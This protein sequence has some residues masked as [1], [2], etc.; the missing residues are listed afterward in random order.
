MRLVFVA[1][2]ALIIAQ[3]A[4]AGACPVNSG[5]DIAVYGQTGTGGVGD[6]SRSWMVHFFD[7][8]KAQDASLDYAMLDAAD[9]KSDCVLAN[10]PGLKLYVEPGGD[11]YKQQKALG[12]A[13][14]SNIL[15]FIDGGK[16]YLGVCAGFYYAANDYY[17]QGSYYDWPY[18]LDRFPTVEGSITSIADYEGDP[19]YAMTGLGNGH[20]VLYYGGPTRGWSQTPSTYPGVKMA[21]FSA[22]PG[23]LPAVIANGN[24]LLTSVHLEAYENDGF[25]GLTTAQRVENYKWLANM[26]NGVA[27][28]S[29]YVPPYTQC[30]DGIDNDDDGNT[31]YPADPGCASIE[32][33]SETN[34]QCSDGLDNDNDSFVDYPADAGCS[35]AS[36]NDETDVS[37]PVQLFFD[38]FESGSLS[39]WTLSK[40]SGANFWTAATTN[41]YQGSYHAQAR[42][43]Y[44]TEPATSMEMAVSTAG[45]GAV[46]VS[47][48]RR[49]VGLDPA[50][51]FKAK[52]FDGTSW[53]VMEETGASSANDAA[54]VQKQFVLPAPAGDNPAFGIKFECTAGATT[55]YCRVDNVEV[56]GE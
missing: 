20:N 33:D 3:L 51:E 48:S 41:P 12:S 36:D 40:A 28:T 11:A 21:S 30:H 55:E 32:D 52:W 1:V 42:P 38:G 4:F 7:W 56:T 37:G 29:F 34:P 26:I 9:V 8:W 5:T 22:I 23:E 45:Y 39:G 44:A 46:T 16:A 50:D 15:N 6:L 13:G 10:Y 43:M 18:T 27:N 54:Y 19:G 35:S 31:D 17:W 53:N 47:Y 2:I 24:M 14:R 25:S 49:L